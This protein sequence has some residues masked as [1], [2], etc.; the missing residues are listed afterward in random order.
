[1]A[2]GASPV[3]SVEGTRAQSTDGPVCIMDG[4]L[5]ARTKTDN[6]Y[7]FSSSLIEFKSEK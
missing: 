2:T 1:M 5:L 6:V 3:Q 4:D 7:N